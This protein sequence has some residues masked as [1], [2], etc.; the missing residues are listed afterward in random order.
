MAALSPDEIQPDDFGFLGLL[1]VA[2]IAEMAH[3]YEQGSK[4]TQLWFSPEAFSWM[5]V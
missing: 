1:Q 3:G 2:G 5:K 4:G